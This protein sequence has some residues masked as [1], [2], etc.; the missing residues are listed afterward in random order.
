M[1][2]IRKLSGI[3]LFATALFLPTQLGKHFFFPFSYVNGVRIDYLAPTIYFI[4]ILLVFLVLLYWRNIAAFIFHK[5]RF[6][7]LCAVAILLIHVFLAQEPY[8][9][10][11]AFWRISQIF[12]LYIIFSAKSLLTPISLSRSIASTQ[13][14]TIINSAQSKEKSTLDT[15]DLGPIPVIATIYGL[16]AG[17]IMQVVLSAA[18][19]IQKSSLQGIFYYLGERFFTL[20]TPGISTAS[21]NGIEILRPYGTFSHPN[22]MGGFYLLVYAFC[23]TCIAVKRNSK[24]NSSFKAIPIQLLLGLGFLSSFLV[25]ISFSKTAIGT[26]LLVTLVS[27]LYSPFKAEIKKSALRCIP[28]S[29]SQILIPVILGI[30]FFQ[31]K[32]DV[33]SIDKRLYLLQQSM[34]IFEQHAFFGVGLGNYLYKQAVFSQPYAEFFLQPVHNIFMLILVQGGIIAAGICIWIFNKLARRRNAL[35]LIVIIVTGSL[36]HYW[37][38][39]IQNMLL[40][41]VVFGTLEYM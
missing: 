29:V 14:K 8:M 13:R 36:D 15:V 12:I 9:V 30:L 37:I 39:L 21:L 20:S 28:C 10:L 18:Q 7:T 17:S 25:F 40:L 32:G 26:Y 41:G 16:L 3:L 35:I 23:L 31:A 27:V 2:S 19:F 38:T 33:L 34:I 5:A 11:Y 22:S 1:N 24:N 4:D 6:Y